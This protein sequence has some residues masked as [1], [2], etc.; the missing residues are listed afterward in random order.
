MAVGSGSAPT[1]QQHTVDNT[2]APAQISAGGACSH[3]PAIHTTL[4]HAEI[5]NAARIESAGRP[6]SGAGLGGGVSCRGAVF[7]GWPVWP[8]WPGEADIGVVSLAAGRN[9]APVLF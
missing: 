3:C 6:P 5:S 7:S 4:M 2:S 8:V 1:A 9:V